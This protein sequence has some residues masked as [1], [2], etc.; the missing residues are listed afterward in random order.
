MNQWKYMKLTS[1]KE[2]SSHR[3]A[4][5]KTGGGQKPPSPSP[6]S[7][8]IAEMIP[9]EFEIDYNEFDCDGFKVTINLACC[10]N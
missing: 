6:E 5:N 7:K 10:L 3:R 8:E 9:L 1:K 4:I 2:L